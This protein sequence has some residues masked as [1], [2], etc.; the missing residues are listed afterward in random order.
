MKPYHVQFTESGQ[1]RWQ[2]FQAN[3]PGN[4]FFK[5]KRAHPKAVLKQCVLE[6]WG[7]MEGAVI[8]YDA[9]RNQAMPTRAKLD[10]ATQET[11]PFYATEA[12]SRKPL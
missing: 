7:F 3:S 8:Q 1:D 6:G 10:N 12:L 2:S 4:A 5:C 9:P 11:M